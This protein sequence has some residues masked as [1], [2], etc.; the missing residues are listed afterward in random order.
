MEDVYIHTHIYMLQILSE[1]ESVFG[2]CLMFGC[3][4]IVHMVWNRNWMFKI[5][6]SLFLSSSLFV[7]LLYIHLSVPPHTH[8]LNRCLYIVY[9]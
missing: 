8:T 6:S 4:H 1:S 2:F 5:S 3:L 7:Y 9:I